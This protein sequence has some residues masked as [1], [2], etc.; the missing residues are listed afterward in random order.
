M[1]PNRR[2]ALL[3]ALLA[4]L[5][6]AGC[7]DFFHPEGSS[8]KN[9]NNDNNGNKGGSTAPATPSNVQTTATSPSTITVTWASVSGA[10]GYKIYRSGSASGAYS[11]Q[12]ESAG[13]SYADTGVSPDT[14]Y[15]YKVSAYNDHGESARSS[16]TSAKTPPSGSEPSKAPTT[17]SNVQAE[18]MSPDTIA[19]GWHP[20]SGAE[21]YRIYR[22]NSSTGNYSFVGEG[23]ESF[24]DIGLSPNTTYYYKV[25]AYNDHGESAQ[26]SEASA[27]T[28]TSGGLNNSLVGT[29]WTANDFGTIHEITFTSPTVL[30]YAIYDEY[31]PYHPMTIQYSYSY[32]GGSNL[33][34][35][36]PGG[37]PMFT[38]T[39]STNSIFAHMDGLTFHKQN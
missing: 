4:A 2:N 25:S 21:G 23:Y 36:D 37:Y 8:N 19:V 5:L 24:N 27:K 10:S 16:E 33:T 28:P 3:F 12:G 17:P 31:S 29:T 13:G 26:S 7:K 14:R 34:I 18:A 6:F 38:Y 39:V 15:Y 22:S 35:N 30:S 9:N 32:D 11:F 20:V 1:K